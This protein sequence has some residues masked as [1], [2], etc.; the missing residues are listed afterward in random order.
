MTVGYRIRLDQSAP[1]GRRDIKQ[2]VGEGSSLSKLLRRWSLV[3]SPIQRLNKY[4]FEG[5]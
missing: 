5:G 1:S 2:I 3:P 4:L